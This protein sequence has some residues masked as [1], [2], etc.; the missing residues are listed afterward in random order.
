MTK[1]EAKDAWAALTALIT[2]T[3]SAGVLPRVEA[4][5]RE[6]KLEERDVEQLEE[7]PIVEGRLFPVKEVHRKPGRRARYVA[8]VE[9]TEQ[10]RVRILAEAILQAVVYPREMEHDVW[11]YLEK[12]SDSAGNP[13]GIQTIRVV[14]ETLGDE[15]TVG[16]LRRETPTADLDKL[17]KS[18]Q[19]IIRETQK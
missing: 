4:Y 2:N 6:G 8:V 12:S 16:T 10:E 11:N 3:G 7:R 1:Q 15:P 9:Y 19:E 13:I 14:R 5:L 17:E 18:L